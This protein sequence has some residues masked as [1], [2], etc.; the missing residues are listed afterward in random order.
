MNIESSPVEGS[1]RVYHFALRLETLEVRNWLAVGMIWAGPG[2][3]ETDRTPCRDFTT[4]IPQILPSLLVDIE[5]NAVNS[6][7]RC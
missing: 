2:C 6:S 1:I 4:L 5:A 7:N 3:R